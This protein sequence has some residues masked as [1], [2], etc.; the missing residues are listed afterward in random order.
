MHKLSPTNEVT[1]YVDEA[2]GPV[3][4]TPP[5]DGRVA[6]CVRVPDGTRV[7]LLD[8]GELAVWPQAAR[9]ELKDR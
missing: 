2:R 8:G 1:V 6:V 9:L 7:E 4:I 5:L 3:I